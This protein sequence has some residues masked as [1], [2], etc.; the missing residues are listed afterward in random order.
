MTDSDQSTRKFDEIDRRSFIGVAG[1]AS[2][3]Q[4]DPLNAFLARSEAKTETHF[5]EAA[6]EFELLDDGVTPGRKEGPYR[7]NAVRDEGAFLALNR[8]APENFNKL[9]TAETVTFGL[10]SF[11]TGDA[12]FADKLDVLPTLASDTPRVTR[13][14][15][16]DQWGGAPTYSVRSVGN[17]SAVVEVAGD[18]VEVQSDA[19]RRIELDEQVIPAERVP[20][21]DSADGL[22]VAPRLEVRNYG[23]VAVYDARDEA[24]TR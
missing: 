1:G 15:R 5:V 18:R 9:V 23:Q 22:A 11:E 14:L 19:A 3:S 24:W 17:G 20:G 10:E 21:Y 7:Y 2:L 6:L 12:T 4:L 8:M 13:S 16:L